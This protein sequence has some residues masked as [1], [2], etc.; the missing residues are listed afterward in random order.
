M[1]MADLP[2]GSK[3]GEEVPPP[4]RAAC[5]VS[6]CLQ[7]VS[8]HHVLGYRRGHRLSVQLL[9]LVLLAAGWLVYWAWI[10]LWYVRMLLS[11]VVVFVVVA[12]VA[13][14][15]A[16]GIASVPR[17]CAHPTPLTAAR[18]PLQQRNRLRLVAWYLIDFLQ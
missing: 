14:A 15:A 8:M 17:C 7:L 12:A 18:T 11:Y 6:D 1:H 2:D 3:I 16:A 13:A 9:P 10:Q 5:S 4:L